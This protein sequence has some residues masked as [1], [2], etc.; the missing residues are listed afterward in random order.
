MIAPTFMRPA[1]LLAAS[2]ALTALFSS[3][4]VAQNGTVGVRDDGWTYVSDIS[5]YFTIAI[6]SCEIQSW[7]IADHSGEHAFDI[8]MGALPS[9]NFLSSEIKKAMTDGQSIYAMALLDLIKAKY[10]L[11]EVDEALKKIGYELID[12]NS[13]APHN[14]DEAWA[15]WAHAGPCGSAALAETHLKVAQAGMA[16]LAAREGSDKVQGYKEEIFKTAVTHLAQ[17]ASFHATKLFPA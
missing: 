9:K 15:I 1:C 17:A 3:A 5:G 16:T 2:L 6:D 8:L 12:D 11:H 14:L 13:G 10:M 7:A 4:V